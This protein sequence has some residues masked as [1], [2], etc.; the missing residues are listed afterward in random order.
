M[1]FLLM[2]CILALSMAATPTKGDKIVTQL[3]GIEMDGEIFVI[4]FYDPSC[5]SDP[6]RTINNDVKQDLEKN[7]LSTEQGKKYVFYEID[8]SDL[9]MEPVLDKCQIDKY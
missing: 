7:V 9:D 2:A 5:C 3:E 1:K 4:L 8:A 6:D